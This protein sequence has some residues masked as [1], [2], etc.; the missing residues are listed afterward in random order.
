[1][2]AL[3]EFEADTSCLSLESLST[4]DPDGFQGFI[5]ALRTD[6]LVSYVQMELSGH[7]GY[8][9]CSSDCDELG[10]GTYDSMD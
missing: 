2:R 9:D 1:M 6:T 8:S 7:T 3:A 10:T 5:F 4:L